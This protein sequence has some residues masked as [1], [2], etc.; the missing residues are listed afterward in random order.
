MGSLGEVYRKKEEYFQSP[1]VKKE[2]N[3]FEALGEVENGLSVE[4]HLVESGTR[5]GPGKVDGCSWRDGRACG[6]RVLVKEAQTS[7]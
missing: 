7:D 4:Y 1:Q 6:H 5:I 2:A 3:T